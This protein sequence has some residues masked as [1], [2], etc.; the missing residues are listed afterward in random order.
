MS[1]IIRFHEFG[2]S[3]V[4]CFEHADI[5]RPGPREARIRV[6][7]IGLNR[8]EAS[9]RAGHFGVPPFP[10]T[11]GF[12]AAGTIEELGTEVT[13]FAVGDAVAVVPGLMMHEYGTYGE[14]L[15]FPADMLVPIPTGM[16][17]EKAAASWMQFLTAYGLISAGDLKAGDHVLITAASS[18]V[19][20]AAIQ[21]ANRLNAI[22]IAVT[23]THAKRQA[24]ER[25]G[26]AHVI[27]SGEEAMVDRLSAY[28]N[29]AGARVIFD[30]VGGETLPQLVET[31]AYRGTIILYGTLAGPTAP[32]PLVEGM[33]KGVTVRCYSIRDILADPAERENAFAFIHAGMASGAL[34]AVIDRIFPFEEIR[35]AHDYL[36]SNGQFGKIVVRVR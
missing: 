20:L 18:S 15:L 32:L 28:T 13:G 19:G 36:E 12:E 2:L 24:L 29:G 8:A 10:S 3:D 14:E 31:V 17:M 25:H 33:N 5:G 34:D 30:S 22:P 35:A 23:R 6:H 26:A 7:A 16:P 4:L 1:R 27:A 11:I 21:I 9:Y